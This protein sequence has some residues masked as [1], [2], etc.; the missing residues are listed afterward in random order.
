MNLK[1]KTTLAALLTLPAAGVLALAAPAQAA[2]MSE[3]THDTIDVTSDVFACT[4][5]DL[6]VQSGEIDMLLHYNIDNRGYFHFTGTI[7]PQD[8]VLTDG[9]GNTY[10]ISGAD[11]F[12]GTFGTEPVVFTETSNFVIHDAS[13]G[14]YAKVQLVTH[15]SPNASSFSF[16]RGS[17]LT[18]S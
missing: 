1:R 16:D 14:V 5:G 9:S 17:C 3:T 13:G 12:G 15:L 7:T 2:A 18:P 4:G 6:T 8:V 10:S 11:W